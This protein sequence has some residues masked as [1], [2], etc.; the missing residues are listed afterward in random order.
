MSRT[1]A[2]LAVVALLLLSA[3]ARDEA[4]DPELPQGS[5]ATAPAPPSLPVLPLPEEVPSQPGEEGV[6]EFV[7]AFMDLR[8]AGEEERLRDYLS[9]NA[10]G[11]FGQNL[12]LTSMSF[13]GWEL[14]SLNAA[15][16]NSWEARVT[17]R[18]EDNQSE[19]LLFVGP[20]AD[21]DGTQ[22]PWV[23]RGASKP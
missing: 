12:P 20:G 23:V 16:A 22:R 3:C 1:S 17:I 15:D 21:A 10:L 11:Q 2:V 19:E 9:A 13:T 7:T 6:R 4:P 18:R 8:L 14:A 5:T